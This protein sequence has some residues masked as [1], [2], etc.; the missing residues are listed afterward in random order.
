[1]KEAVYL[2]LL[3]FF[4]HYES[5][6]Y[7]L[8]SKVQIV[9]PCNFI[10]CHHENLLRNILNS[11]QVPDTGLRERMWASC[12]QNFSKS[13]LFPITKWIKIRLL[14]MTYKALP[15]ITSPCL[16]DFISCHSSPCT[17]GFGNKLLNSVPSMNILFSPRP[18]TPF[19]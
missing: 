3:D 5:M 17:S 19:L 18:A 2:K 6:E 11:S 12:S 16:S 8:N 7:F 1:M 13:L 14:N 9:L 15:V 4:C 10:Y